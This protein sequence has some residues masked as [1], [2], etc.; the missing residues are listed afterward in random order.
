MI[1]SILQTLT[2][3]CKLKCK[4]VEIDRGF[5][6]TLRDLTYITV[7]MYAE[8][9]KRTVQTATAHCVH[10]ENQ[11]VRNYYY[12]NFSVFLCISRFFYLRKCVRHSKFIFFA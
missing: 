2:V 1:N 12:C 9:V 3:F 7:G 4:Y 5:T 8:H 6:V 10:T 11:V